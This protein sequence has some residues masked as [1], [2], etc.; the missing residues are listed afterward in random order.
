M[1]KR[2]VF[3]TVVALILVLFVSAALAD[4]TMYVYTKNGKPVHVRSSMSTKDRSNIKGSFPY[5]AAVTVYDP[6]YN[7]WAMV[8][9]GDGEDS[10]IMS[11][12]LVYT[13]PGPYNPGFKPDPKPADPTTFNTKNAGTVLQLNTLVGSAKYVQPYLVTVRPTR[14]SGWVY[15]HWFPSRSSEYIATYRSDYQLSVI[16]ELKDWYQVEDPTTGKIGFLY[17]SYLGY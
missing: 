1:K 4:V 8:D 5:G 17:K 6:N 9:F 3:L 11:R 10:Y 13:Q 14:A 2:L 16:A 12:Y 15:M 7:G